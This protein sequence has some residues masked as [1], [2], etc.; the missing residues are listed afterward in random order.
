[1]QRKICVVGLGYVGLP[2]AVAFGKKGKIIGFDI[3]AS[4]IEALRSGKDLTNETSEQELKAADIEFTCDPQMIGGSDFIIVAVPTPVNEAKIPDLA[5]VKS[6]SS[7]VGKFMKRGS[8]VVYESTVYPGVTEDVCVPILEK[9]SGM[10]CGRDFKIGYSPERINPG[11]KEHSLEKI[12]KIVSGMDKETLDCVSTVYGSI[13]AAGVYPVKTIKTA[14]AAKVI[15][16]IQ[17]DLN[18]A[19][20]NELA[21]IFEK[22][23]ICTR[24]VI[25]AACT[26]WNFH[27]YHPG[28][29]GGHCI[30]VDPFYMTYLAL[31]VGIHPKVILAGRDTNDGMSKFVAEMVLKELNKAGHVLKNTTVLIMGLTF[32]E[33]VP[34]KRNSRAFDVV[35]Y[36]REFSINVI[37]CDPLLPEEIV[38]GETEEV[39]NLPFEKIKSYDCVLLINAHAPFKSITLEQLKSKMH[40]FP[41]LI[42]LKSAYSKEEALQK[43]FI[44]KTL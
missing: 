37:G 36:L 29:V 7:L 12:I 38:K 22:I 16:N 8:I 2:L 32:K 17:R 9:E 43:G 10:K 1:M 27:R 40:K 30:G 28:L 33:N 21:I 23:G 3:N 35:R 6:A 19:L 25:D 31:Q 44:Y 4:R 14:E 18:I 13:I 24:D 34:D 26:K 41:I 11:D 15:E 42:D 5:A 20:M 39:I